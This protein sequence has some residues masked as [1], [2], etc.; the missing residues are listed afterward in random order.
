MYT[1]TVRLRDVRGAIDCGAED[2]RAIYKRYNST[3][4]FI[5]NFCRPRHLHCIA[6]SYGKYGVSGVICE[7]MHGTLY[8]CPDRSAAT[9]VVFDM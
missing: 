3:L 9:M 5:H 7:D 4:D 6:R 8:A 1:T 2:L